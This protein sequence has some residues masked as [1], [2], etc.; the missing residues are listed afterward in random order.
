MS[1]TTHV[2]FVSGVPVRLADLV[3]CSMSVFI[4]ALDGDRAE[5]GCALTQLLGL[6]VGLY[7][8]AIWSGPGRMDAPCR[9]LATG[10]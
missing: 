9:K 10:C 7:T 6:L 3:V 1:H 8:P 2:F 5:A 4:D